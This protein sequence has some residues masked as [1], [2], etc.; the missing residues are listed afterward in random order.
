MT[1]RTSLL[2]PYTLPENSAAHKTSVL[3]PGQIPQFVRDDPAFSTFVLF[4]ESYYEWM[5]QQNGV[6]F[7]SKGIPEFIDVDTTLDSFLDYFKNE[8]MAFFPAEALVD[9]RKLIKVAR[10]LYQAKGT[11]ASFKFLF[12]VLF[13]SDVDLYNTKDYIFRASDGKWI[14]TKSLKLATN[15]T[16]W[17]QTAN[18]LIF[19]EDSKS[20]ATIENIYF[21]G[22]NIRVILSNIQG[23]FLAGEF[24]RVVDVHGRDF[25]VNSQVPRAKI[26]GLLTGVT[27]DKKNRG[28]SYSVGDPVVFY[29][30]LDPDI[31][32]PIG[33]SG[34]IS[35]VTSA[36]VK[37][38]TSTYPGHGYR[39]GAFTEVNITSTTGAN[40]KAVATEFTPNPYY[41]QLV[42]DD[43]IGDKANIYL[44]NTE[45]STGADPIGNSIYYF[46]NLINA[47]ANSVLE[48]ALTFPILKTYG[49][50]QVEVITT[51]TG[52]DD[53]TIAN[54]I[55][56]YT[57]DREEKAPLPSLGILPPPTIVNGGKNYNV[58]DEVVFTGG[59]GYGA[60]GVVTGVS[61]QTGAVT[62]IMFVTDPSGARYPLGGMGY[63]TM[64]PDVTVRSNTGSGA[65]FTFP[66]V[67][68]EDAEFNVTAYP[69][70]QVLT[71]SLTNPGENYV[72]KPNVSLRVED[73]LVTLDG[74]E[75]IRGDIL[76]QGD[77]NTPTYQ[78]FFDSQETY[79]LNVVSLRTYNYNG[80]LNVNNTIHLARGA[81]TVS[82]NIVVEGITDSKYTNG[83]KIYG[84]GI[85]KANAVFTNGITLGSGIYSN[86]DGQPSAYS[87]F[88]NEVYNEY[89]YLL[90]VEEALAKYKNSVMAFLHPAGLN[91][92]AYNVLKNDDSYDMKM[93]TES[94]STYQMKDLI[95][96]KYYVAN[97]SSELS[98]TIVFSNLD[99][100]NIAEVVNV[101]SFITIYPES[102]GEG[103]SSKITDVTSNTI[104]MQDEWITVVPNV[105]IARA[106][107]GSAIINISEL[108]N[109]W[110]IATGNTVTYFSD[111]IHNYDYVSFDGNTY[112]QVVSVGQPVYI[113][114]N[115]I[116]PTTITVN[117][118]Y[119][120][121]QTGYLAFKQNVQSSNIWI[122]SIDPTS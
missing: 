31:E 97:I 89:T 3:V 75:P 67:V 71:I 43:T 40:A 10:Q 38:I 66:G 26:I 27:V 41:I 53:T 8:F 59:T 99:S 87:I 74:A 91:Y 24:I 23:S 33:A 81:N 14:A 47:N 25:E 52:Y 7:N 13:N 98:N 44:G 94:L 113:N 20:Y 85:A 29:G 50:E 6:L 60:Y 80:Q 64:F 5:E 39:K 92:N 112:K 103:F 15:D 106:N 69:Y 57:T 61:T 18:Y 54:A 107:S 65:I 114:N 115:V 108:T 86:E 101:G 17:L 109:S 58:G 102:G 9:E 95:S 88:E 37:G 96:N 79:A 63:Y 72:E 83:R 2:V 22:V 76:Y 28:H 121:N 119:S 118:S 82:S 73:I 19:G 16:R 100:A 32:N 48:E 110:N 104:T 30:G 105:V 56:Y 111:F 62:N 122:S 12:R 11:P 21:D 46:A 42:P 55:G 93:N 49:I 51:G 34:Y 90:Q 117:S 70:G 35:Q 116:V 78:S 45:F 77:F 36:S 4:L 1:D 68:G 84:N 120:S